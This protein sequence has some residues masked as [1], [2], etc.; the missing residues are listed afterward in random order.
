MLGF[1]GV[2]AVFLSALLVAVADAVIKQTTLTGNFL[3]ALLSPWILLICTLYFL[4]VLLALYIF[5][6]RGDLAV[7]GMLFNVFY[8]IAMILLGVLVFKEH[9]TMWQSVGIALAL[10]GTMLINSGL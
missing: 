4:Q 7:Y 6:N 2:A 5:L 8:S 10:A 3:S 9:I 1:M